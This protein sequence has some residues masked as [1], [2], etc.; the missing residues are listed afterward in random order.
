MQKYT[1]Y[2]RVY[3]K[4]D[5]Q[6]IKGYT[7]LQAGYW[8]YKRRK[9]TYR[10]A[11]AINLNNVF[12][13]GGK[14]SDEAEKYGY[15]VTITLPS[16]EG[17]TFDSAKFLRGNDLEGVEFTPEN[18]VVNADKTAITFAP[19]ASDGIEKDGSL[20][21]RLYYSKG[22]DT[23][24]T[25][26][27]KWYPRPDKTLDSNMLRQ[28][29]VKENE[30]I[31]PPTQEELL[32]YDTDYFSLAE[33]E[34]WYTAAPRKES[35]GTYT[36]DPEKEFKTTD[37]VTAD[38]VTN[39]VLKLYAKPKVKAGTKIPVGLSLELYG[40]TTDNT[41]PIGNDLHL[42]YT[43]Q[44]TAVE[45]KDYKTEL[46]WL[47]PI[48][49][50]WTEKN[51]PPTGEYK[52]IITN[53]SSYPIPKKGATV[54]KWVY[55]DVNDPDLFHEIKPGEKLSSDYV[56]K[57]LYHGDTALQAYSNGVLRNTITFNFTDANLTQ[58]Y[59]LETKTANAGATAGTLT[60][61]QLKTITDAVTSKE[62]IE[63]FRKLFRGWYLTQDHTGKEVD[64]ATQPFWGEATLY[65]R[66]ED[67]YTLKYD[68]GPYT[69]TN[70]QLFGDTRVARGDKL[71]EPTRPEA[72]SVAFVGWYK[73]EDRKEAWNFAA[74][75]VSG[76]VTL[77]AKFEGAKQ[78]PVTF[79]R[80]QAD[81]K[82]EKAQVTVR[83]NTPVVANYPFGP[84]PELPCPKKGSDTET[85]WGTTIYVDEG[86]K[87]TLT[88]TGWTFVDQ[89]NKTQTLTENTILANYLAADTKS[90]EVTAAY[91]V[92]FT[93]SFDLAGGTPKNK[94]DVAAIEINAESGC[95]KKPADDPE[96][97][98][99]VFVK[100]I[101]KATGAEFNFNNACTENTVIQAEWK[102]EEPHTVKFKLI[103]AEAEMRLWKTDASDTIIDPQTPKDKDGNV[104][105]ALK[106]GEYTY[107]A[108]A[109]GYK[110][111]S[112]TKTVTR[113][114]SDE[115]AATINEITLPPFQAVTDIEL[116]I[117]DNK[118]MQKKS[119]DLGSLATVAPEN[120]SNKTIAWT[121]SG[122]DDVTLG[123]DGKTLTVSADATGSVTLIATIT[124]GK[125]SDDGTAEADYTQDFTL[126]ITK[127]L[128]T[129]S[130]D[131]GTGDHPNVE[132][133][134]PQS[135][136]DDSTL[137]APTAPSASGWTFDGWYKEAACTTKWEKND[138][139][140]VDTT[141][142]AKWTKNP[143]DV[144]I[145]FAGGEGA[146]LNT[147]A[148][149]THNGKSGDKITL[150]PCMYTKSGYI[151]RSWD[152]NFAGTSYTLPEEAKTFT[153]AWTQISA[154]ISEDDITHALD[155]LTVKDAAGNDVAIATIQDYKPQ[156][157]AV[158][159]ALAAGTATKTD[160]TLIAKL[161][162][163]FEAAGLG[164][165]SIDGDA[166]NGVSEVGAIL[167]S[168]GAKVVLTVN[169]QAT[170]IKTLPDAYKNTEYKAVWYNLSMTVG[171]ATTTPK[172]P[173][174]LTMPIPADLSK[175]AADTIRVLLYK[176]GAT[177]PVVMT[178]T[179][180]GSNLTFAYDG[181]GDL[182]IVGKAI[183]DAKDTRVTAL[184]MRYNGTK[185]GN[186]EQDANGN[187]TV[188]LPSTTSESVLQDL[189]SGI[190]SKWITY[191]TVAPQAKVKPAEG[192]EQTAEYW[193]KTGVTLTYSLTSDNKYSATQN[194]TVTA[195]DGT[196]T[197]TFTVTVKKITDA[198]RTYKIAVANISGG[199]VT[200]TP[201][202]AA[203]G[204]E[205]KLTVEPNDGKKLIAG[206]LSYCLQSAGAKSVPI[207]ESSLTFIMPAG[208]ININAQFE[209]D[210]NAP[211][212]NP[213][214]ITAFVVNGVSAVINSDTKA[215]T[216]I[217]PY[218]TDLRHVAPTIVTANASKVK[219]SSAQRVDLSTPK[220]YRVYASNGAYVTYTVTAYTEEPSPTQSLWEKLQN[221]INSSPNWWE[222]A[223]YQKKAGYYR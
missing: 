1:V 34:A 176:N 104:V 103:P 25:Y 164:P 201:N 77:Y 130:F 151:F 85:E 87:R 84:L 124:N 215:I 196:T 145:T 152:G 159:D 101:N 33:V 24:P 4:D 66:W 49:S 113:N 223:E 195:G 168:D 53:A 119:Y 54:D 88:Y 32:E 213:P 188:T 89:E 157:L 216:I 74:D 162:G 39:K 214:Q 209:D 169:K 95:A 65:A 146:T 171:G 158:R 136:K 2:I 44:K 172:V 71:S 42:H 62:D 5:D 6:Q 47:L 203:A 156:L 67:A 179:V 111:V 222:L 128:A 131:H 114:W 20:T 17:Y 200:A 70:K 116:N 86:T 16:V 140:E 125:L 63:G 60:N 90:L 178:P 218:G 108:S 132:L 68:F 126:T 45:R 28:Q 27:V 150:P 26:T 83:P 182:A 139:F 96:K 48:D 122:N 61:E 79:T 92:S 107:A 115:D 170:P 23:T 217:L 133:P 80:A 186:I 129:I 30:A 59:E 142:Y 22:G 57:L 117:P 31:T 36:Y 197:R 137:D 180:N 123:E 135:V 147:G 149:S 11:N 219:P 154:A 46:Y 205:V 160:A 199:T 192:G 35:D 105:Y 190:N 110:T 210:A 181:N 97:D 40:P 29:P 202:P 163:L 153:A 37:P 41:L 52:D 121:V 72:G 99:Y 207:D 141:L 173:V 8:E 112:G 185:M 13:K 118:I 56:L 177:Q 9:I 43:S 15:P 58:A 94:S 12:L 19:M 191:M 73:D 193:A 81:N 14:T 220:A 144:T 166:K 93:I 189:A 194:F 91:N 102:E 206:S 187:F 50:E 148:S 109:K 204:E 100:W 174:I 82:N 167:S 138:T 7:G 76:D 211:L 155:G 38:M 198:D 120:A 127:Y 18:S 106:G 143:V 69:P 161:S 55:Q 134:K 184:E 175:M 51:V 212:K 75:T 98:G 208:D 3:S 21:V 183:S 221:Q 64:P 78:I 165:V 10:S